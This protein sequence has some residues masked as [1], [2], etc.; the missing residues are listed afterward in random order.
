MKTYL[1]KHKVFFKIFVIINLLVALSQTGFAQ[2]PLCESKPTM[3]GYEYITSVNINGEV[4]TGN[5]GYAGPGYIDYTNTNI[6]NLVAGQTYP[7][8]ITVQ[9]NTTWH[10]YVKVWFDFNGNLNLED[11]GELVFNQDASWDGLYTFSGTIT[12]PADAYNGDVYVRINMVYSVI[13]QLCGLYGYG[14][15]F[16]YKANISGGLTPKML[17]VNT[18]GASGFV[19]SVVSVPAGINTAKGIYSA[20]FPQNAVVTLIETN[21]TNG[22]F[23]DWTGDATGTSSTIDVT[24]DQDKNIT[25]NFTT[26]K[27]LDPT[28]VTASMSVICLGNTIQLEAIGAQGDV[29]WYSESCGGQFIGIGNPISVNPT[30]ATTYFARNFANGT[31]SDGCASTTVTMSTVPASVFVKSISLYAGNFNISCNGKNDGAVTVSADGGCLPYSYVWSNGQTN[32]TATNLT[33]GTYSV[34]VT[35]ANGNKSNISVSLTEPTKLLSDISSPYVVSKYNTSCKIEGDGTISLVANGGVSPYL[36][37]WSN[38]TQASFNLSGLKVGSYSATITDKNGCIATNAI[39]LTKPDNCNCLPTP[40]TPSV[41]CDVCQEIIDGK[42]N[43][44]LTTGKV[45]CVRTNFNGNINTQKSTLV[46]CGDAIINSITLND[47]DKLIVLGKLTVQNFNINTTTIV[48]ENY[49]TINVTGSANL[50][51]KM[52]NNGTIT[53]QALNI[54]VDGILL[55]NAYTTIKSNFNFNGVFVNNGKFKVEGDVN[56]NSGAS[57]TNNCTLDLANISIN[58]LKACANNGTLTA[59]KQML[60]N[61]AT[62]QL[63][64]GSVIL[65]N[66]FTESQSNLINAGVNCN[67]LQVATTTLLNNGVFNGPIAYCDK[68]GIETNN[69]AKLI[70]GATFSCSSCLYVTSTTKSNLEEVEAANENVI[71]ATASDASFSVYPIPVESEGNITIALGDEIKSISIYNVLGVK[72]Y[73]KTVNSKSLSVSGIELGTGTFVIKVIGKDGKT[74]ERMAIVK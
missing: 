64:Q 70:N 23:I 3:F 48:C 58:S 53:F 21:A 25:A 8:S 4:R 52:T 34:T 26:S 59:T 73:E 43:V 45:S 2:S 16:D 18:T 22:S 69:N 49:G 24:L 7:I 51:G 62:F 54:N 20:N 27:P 35:D 65:A 6:T 50:N 15:T 60:L 74:F 36:V 68:N 1:Q 67:L 71:E 46:I 72:V 63:G 14:N 44:N 30:A 10:E 19:G 66:S 39:T 31:F 11:A 57:F 33:A 55:N 17:T 42:T 41:T 37:S 47:G 32:P 5:T 38:G 40:A 12:V 13:P 9:T 29:Y 56:L 28:A 61:S